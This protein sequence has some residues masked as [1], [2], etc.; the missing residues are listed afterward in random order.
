MLAVLCAPPESVLA[1][2]VWLGCRAAGAERQRQ[3]TQTAAKSPHQEDSVF[4][5]EV[6][7]TTVQS[8]SNA[9]VFRCVIIFVTVWT[10]V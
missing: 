10:C 6:F 4:A 7:K 9:N 8:L 5:G 1:A 2:D 3:G